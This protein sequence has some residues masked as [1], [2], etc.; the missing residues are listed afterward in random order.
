MVVDWWSRDLLEKSLQS[1]IWFEVYYHVHKGPQLCQ[2]NP[3]NTITPCFF[4]I[5]FYLKSPKCFHPFSYAFFSPSVRSTWHSH[6]I[7]HFFL[8]NICRS[9]QVNSSLCNFPI[10][11]LGF[12]SRRWRPERLWG[13]T[14]LLSNGHQGLLPWGWSGRCVKLTTHLHLLPSSK[15]AW[16]YI[17]T[18]P[19]RLHDVVIGLKKST[20]TT[21]HLPLPLPLP[22][23]WIYGLHVE[24]FIK[25]IKGIGMYWKILHEIKHVNV[26]TSSAKVRLG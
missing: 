25:Y 19:I 10:G 21:L 14:S 13:L 5:H 17:V 1:L 7:L 23:P 20:R 11:V 22:L 3:M 18:P 16:S 9:V 26:E 15:N 8:L 12:D 6:H 2:L 4:K 24:L